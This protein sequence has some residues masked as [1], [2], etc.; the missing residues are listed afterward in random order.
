VI[1]RLRAAARQ[2]RQEVDALLIAR[3]N[4]RVPLLAR[5]V[6][7]ATVAYALSPVDL[8][9]DA[10]P[11]LGLLDDLLIV[12]L[13]VGLALRLVPPE[14]M[15][16]ARAEAARRPPEA[17]RLGRLGLVLVVLAWAVLGA[18]GVGLWHRLR[19]G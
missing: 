18:M 8:I 2:L 13:G 9:P 7:V 11:V 19:H 15:A 5:V 10:I 14:V 12:P 1:A 4:P 6:I 16:A 3:H 17:G